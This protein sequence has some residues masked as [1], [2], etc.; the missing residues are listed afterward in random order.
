MN[1]YFPLG[2]T[3]WQANLDIQPVFNEF[4]AVSYMCAYFSK[5]EDQTSQA[6]KQAAIEAKDM[7]VSKFEK[8]KL[9]ARAYMNK[10]ECSLQE[11]VYQMLPELWLRK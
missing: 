7:G 5:S 2:L 11:A 8:M 9:I 3:C 10:R 1:N 6:M 4:K